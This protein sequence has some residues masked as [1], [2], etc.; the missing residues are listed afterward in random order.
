MTKAHNDRILKDGSDKGY[1]IRIG[2]TLPINS[3]NLAYVSTPKMAPKR[4]F[5]LMIYQAILKKMDCQPH[6][7][8]KK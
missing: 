4:I 1:S 8:L 5:K 3:A 2:K 6:I 7:K